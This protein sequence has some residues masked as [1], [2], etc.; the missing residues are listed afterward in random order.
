MLRFKEPMCEPYCYKGKE[1][2]ILSHFRFMAILYLAFG[3]TACLIGSQ[4]LHHTIIH[5]DMA[6]Q[7]AQTQR[8]DQKGLDLFR[9]D[10]M[11][12]TKIHN[13]KENYR[14]QQVRAI[15]AANAG[16]TA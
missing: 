14:I 4:S 5:P 1:L 16:S 12:G 15:L 9:T 2:N 11:H 8:S 13:A 7:S 6:N 3:D 10:L